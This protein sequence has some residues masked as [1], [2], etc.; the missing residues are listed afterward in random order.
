MKKC[1]KCGIEKELTEFYKHP[2]MAD[3]TVNKCKECNKKDV[4]DNRLDKK[5]YYDE[6]DRNRF[7]KQE[8]MKKC[9][10][11]VRELYFTDDE[12]RENKLKVSREYY[13]N[14]KE[15]I[16]VWQK[17]WVERNPEKVKAQNAVGNAVRDGRLLKPEY[18]QHCN[19]NER[20]IQGHHWSYLNEHWLDVVW[21]C[22]KCHAAEHKRLRELNQDPDKLIEMEKQHERET[23]AV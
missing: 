21:L 11:R 12:F 6:F 10:E 5:E 14:N 16:Q 2:R 19:T 1:F 9:H 15:D 8:R 23:S 17:Q 4:R 20:Q 13:Q 7:N 22:T 18:C 3:G